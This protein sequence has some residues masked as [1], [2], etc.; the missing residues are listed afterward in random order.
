MPTPRTLLIDGDSF[1]YVAAVTNESYFE[2]PNGAITNEADTAEAIASFESTI[3][4]LKEK[5]SASQVR[6]AMTGVENFRK[7]VYP[8]Y[9]AKRG[10]KPMALQAVKQHAVENMGA[11]LKEPLEADDVIGIWATHPK[12]EPGRERVVVS[13]DKD[14][15]TVPGMLTN[16]KEDIE[17]ITTSMANYFFLT[18][19][20]TGDQTDNYPGLPKSGPVAAAAILAPFMDDKGGFLARP[21]WS[22][23]VAAY[24]KKGFT[25][26]DALVQARVARILRYR[27]Y[28]FKTKEPILWTPSA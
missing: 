20:I 28:N 6:I 3:E 1:A 8:A 13:I 16:G 17:T 25:A 2:W 26:D 18:Q 15:R 22:A 19:A 14:L 7:A 23:V 11:V 24:E 27:D 10:K 21:A 5:F 12:L 4:H 9:K